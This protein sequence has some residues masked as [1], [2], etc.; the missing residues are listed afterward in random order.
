MYTPVLLPVSDPSPLS[1]AEAGDIL[2]MREEEQLAH[3]LYSRWYGMYAVPVFSN[4]A[5]SE[6]QHINEVQLLVERYGL[7]GEQ[8]G[9]AT[10]GY[11]NPAIRSLYTSLAARGDTSLTGAFEA[12]LAVEDQDIADLDRALSNTTRADI[13]QVYSN[14]RQGSENH[15]S[16]F[17]RQLGR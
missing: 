14:L 2:F 6:T 1:E 5:A 4:I 7:P 8:I 13:I 12:G 10:T 17:L 16:A 3:D 11:Q 15:R 9:N